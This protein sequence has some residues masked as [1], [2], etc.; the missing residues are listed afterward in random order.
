[1][2]LN[3]IKGIQMEEEFEVIEE[4]IVEFEPFI[5]EDIEES[6]KVCAMCAI[7]RSTIEGKQYVCVTYNARNKF[8]LSK[9]KPP[10][11][12]FFYCTDFQSE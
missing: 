11:E 8:A 5:E 4:E 3:Q 6:L 10:I 12:D 9:K 2:V 1:M 7:Q